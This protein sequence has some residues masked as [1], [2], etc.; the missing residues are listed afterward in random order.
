VTNSAQSPIGQTSGARRCWQRPADQRTLLGRGRAFAGTTGVGAG[1]S[2]MSAA[3]E[4]LADAPWSL[5]PGE[6]VPGYQLPSEVCEEHGAPPLL[7]LDGMIM[8]FTLETL[9]RYPMTSVESKYRVAHITDTGC[10]V[11]HAT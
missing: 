3:A 5:A 10:C 4:P 8:V 7:L 1:F 2:A 9:L 11:V 6:A